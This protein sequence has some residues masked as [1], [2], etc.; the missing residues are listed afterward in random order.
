MSADPVIPLPLTW[1]QWGAI[2]IP[3]YIALVFWMR[4]CMQSHRPSAPKR[5]TKGDPS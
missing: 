4:W 2:L 3:L 5:K 1:D